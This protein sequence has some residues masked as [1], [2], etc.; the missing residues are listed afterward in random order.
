[1]GTNIRVDVPHTW[2]H[3]RIIR[4]RVGEALRGMAMW[5]RPCVPAAAVSTTAGDRSCHHV[6]EPTRDRSPFS[7]RSR[8]GALRDV[9]AD[10]RSRWDGSAATRRR[11]E[12]VGSR[13]S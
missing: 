1:M 5:T 13:G 7:L 3:V 4:E 6:D 11:E 8:L 10:P 9:A 2:S 12:S